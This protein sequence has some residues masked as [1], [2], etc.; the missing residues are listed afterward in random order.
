MS[1]SLS[2]RIPLRRTLA[3]SAAATVVL[4]SGLLVAGEAAAVDLPDAL[5][6]T[7]STTWSYSDDD[8]DPAAGLGDRLAWTAPDFDDAAWKTAAGA[9]GAKNGQATGLGGAF[10]VTTLLNQYADGAGAPNVR[11]FHFRTDFTVDADQLDEI[12]ALQATVTYDD[13][14]QVFVNGEQVAGFADARVNAAPE[15]ERNLVYAGDSA[16]DPVT[17]T[18]TVSPDVLHEGSNTVA[19][20][21]YQDR[22]TSS[23]IYFDFASLA[24][25][26]NGAPADY[27]DIVQTIGADEASRNITWY[28]NRDTAQSVQFAKVADPVAAAADFPADDATTIPAEG[29][30]TSSGEFNRRATIAG[31]AENSSYLYRVGSDATGWSEPRSITTRGFSGDYSFLFFGDPQLG[32][33]GNLASDAAGW[34]DTLDVALA[35]YPGTE[36][37]FS[38]GDQVNTASSEAEYESYLAPE[39]MQNLATVPVNGN[40]DVGSK[41]YEQHY[42]VP[43]LDPESGA[44]AN[45][46][47][48]GG[49]YWFEYKDVLF[50]VLNS[51]SS[52]YASH[53]EFMNRVVAEHGDEAKWKVLAFHHSIYSVASHVFD[54]QIKDLRAAIP[55]T[56]SDLGFDLVLQ[57]HDHS[58]TRSYLVKDGEL[59][60]AEE[61]PGQAEVTA[62]EGE[63]LYVTANSA[64]GSKYYDVK[65]PEAWYAS[66]INQEKVRNYT[67]ID[68]TD[69]AI[70]IS[71]LRS[72]QSGEDKPVNSLVD[73][74]TLHK[75]RPEAP[76]EPTLTAAQESVRQGETLEV[77]GTG[78]SAGEELRVAVHSDPVELDPATADAEGD[79]RVAWTVPADFEV[80]DHA[81]VV[82]RADG[83][84]IEAPFA[85]LA[86][87]TG[88][89]DAGGS[90][91]DASAAG[92]GSGADGS[93][94]SA[95]EGSASPSSGSGADASGSAG[96]GSGSTGTAS[97]NDPLATTGG[98]APLG[99]A[100]AAAI[101]LLA[102][103]GVLLARHARGRSSAPSGPEGSDA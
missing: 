17:S 28:T 48:S 91:T 50:V 9:F 25:Q 96:A 89:S 102:A 35:T 92:S 1:S 8:T 13:A 93:G 71:T 21:L 72:Q 43:N 32:A 4:A 61:T 67:N 83:S 84:E 26:A 31:L 34:A 97:A 3:A 44:A 85:V 99:L 63:V 103:G 69:D 53:I 33:S 51:N 56:I 14:I 19:V 7:A 40:H 52:D 20:A 46:N 55:E 90:G 39:A 95:A 70:T 100:A 41:A 27:S 68:V 86:A 49:D 16:G 38:A 24:P 2:A 94:N 76:A 45:A 36:M 5:I 42:T 62:K 58:Y 98:E 29:G 54:Q 10:P 15:A 23:D 80:G 11:T 81:L 87:E 59:A 82:T 101:L 65:D 75:D 78:F 30:T 6:D 18:F 22:D 12:R 60:N 88:G 66:V 77:A 64:S 57:G 37:L 73:E 74:V 79:V 47:S